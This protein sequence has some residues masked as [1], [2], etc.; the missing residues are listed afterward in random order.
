MNVINKRKELKMKNYK[1]IISSYET[2]NDCGTY[3]YKY[4][5]PTF[6][7]AQNFLEEEFWEFE[8]NHG[9]TKR[10]SKYNWNTHTHEEDPNSRYYYNFKISPTNFCIS[11][12][13][14]DYNGEIE[15][16]ELKNCLSHGKWRF[17]NKHGLPTESGKYLCSLQ[18]FK[19][20]KYTQFVLFSATT[21][22][23]FTISEVYAWTETIQP[24]S[25]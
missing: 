9:L 21:Q 8:K 23:F 11:D 4:D 3:E 2:D 1:V 25:K 20:N 22:E 12:E 14:S 16:E 10:H 17:I 13:W 5:F 7:E 24:A 19:G 15:E 6:E 18:D